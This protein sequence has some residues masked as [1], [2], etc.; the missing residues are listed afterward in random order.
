[1]Q[2]IASL[3]NALGALVASRAGATPP[4]SIEECLTMATI[5]E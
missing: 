4:W 3:A 2:K 5:N 1:M